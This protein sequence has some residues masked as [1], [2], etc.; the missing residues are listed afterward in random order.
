MG[1]AT[2]PIDKGAASDVWTW[3]R[4]RVVAPQGAL[5]AWGLTRAL[6]R[7]RGDRRRLFPAAWAVATAV[8][9]SSGCHVEVDGTDFHL[10]WL[11][12]AITAAAAFVLADGVS[13]N[14][15]RSFVV[16]ALFAAAIALSIAG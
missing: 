2:D 5:A 8:L 15:R 16:S 3:D 11:A 9:A 14:R 12:L 4:W 10:E 13:R 1:P 7:P 6:L